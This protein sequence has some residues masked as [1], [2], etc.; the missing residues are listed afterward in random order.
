MEKAQKLLDDT[1]EASAKKRMTE[2]EKINSGYEKQIKKLD[3]IRDSGVAQDELDR[4]IH[5]VRIE[6]EVEL[7]E[8]K[9][10]AME[11]LAEMQQAQHERTIDQL[12]KERDLRLKFAG[13]ISNSFGEI[14][15]SITAIATAQ[16]DITAS[17]AQRLHRMNQ[18]AAVSGIAMTAAE[19]I[20]SAVATYIGRPAMM[21]TAIALVGA[22]AGLQTGA[23]LAQPPPTFDI[24]GMIGNTDPIQP[25]QTLIRAQTGEAVLDRSTVKELGGE[26]GIRNLKSGPSVIVVSPFKHMDR[27]MKSAM[28]QPT[29]IR[30]M[31]RKNRRRRG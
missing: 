18:A 29:H 3:A 23:V 28:K 17:Q 5:D 31:M 6:R 26:Q 21:A 15:T 20:M 13:D 12:K 27:Y 10:G 14:S 22:T 24:G 19:G 30:R 16:G 2:S 9:R 1:M 8:I 11:R 4:A 7:E 25:D